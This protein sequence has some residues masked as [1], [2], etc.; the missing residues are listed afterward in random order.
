MARSSVVL[1]RSASV[2]LALVLLVLSPVDAQK[3]RT[4]GKKSGGDAEAKK[5]APALPLEGEADLRTFERTTDEVTWLSIDLSPDG[6]TLVLEVLGDL[7]VMPVAGGAATPLPGLEASMGFD[8]QPSISP[9][10]EWVAFV[11][12]RDGAE[13][14]WIAPLAGGEQGKPKQLTKDKKAAFLSPTWSADGDY[15]IVSRAALGFANFEL[16][17]FHVAGGAGVQLTQSNPGGALPRDRRLNAFGAVASPDQR[18]LYYSRRTGGFQYNASFP[19]WQIVRRDLVTGD[20]DVITSAPGSA[21]RPELSPD[22]RLLAYATRID[23]QTGIKVRE[24][25]TG[26]E[27]FVALPVVRDEQESRGTRDNFPGYSFTADGHALIA[28][29]DGKLFR[30]DVAGNTEPVA[31]PFEVTIKK[32]IGPRLHTEQRIEDGPVRARLAQ[33]AVLSPS[34]DHVAFSA[35]A[36]IYVAE[37]STVARGTEPAEAAPPVGLT[38]GD[39]EAY[40]PS[41]SPSG[42]T[43]AFVTWSREGGHIWTMPRTGGTPRRLTNTPAYYAQPT[44][45]PDGSKVVALRAARQARVEMPNEFGGSSLALDLVWVSASASDAPSNTHLIAPARGV[46]QPHFGPGQIEGEPERLYVHSPAGLVSMRLDGSDKRTHLQVKGPGFYSSEE[47]V[48]ANDLLIS[49]DGRWVLA[50]VSNRLFLIALPRVGGEAPTLDISAPSLPAKRISRLGADSFGFARAGSSIHWTVG[51][52]LFELELDAVQFEP[53]SAETRS[54]N[55]SAD[56][57]TKDQESKGPDAPHYPEARSQELVVEVE[58]SIPQGTLVLTG[59]RVITMTGDD[60]GVIEN[61]VVVIENNRIAAVGPAG[62]IDPPE[63][64]TVLDLS[65]KTVVPG[66]IDTHAHW[67]EI[68]RGVLDTDAWTFHAN[69]AYGVTTGLDVQTMTND[70]FAY[71]DMIDAG[72]MIGPRAF[73]TGPGIFSDNNFASKDDALALLER[74]RDHY[75]TR[76]LKAYISGNRQQRQ[77]IVQAASELGMMPTTE[78]AL[79]MKLDLTHAIDGFSGNEHSLPVVPIYKDVAELYAASGTGYTPTLLVSYGGPWAENWFYTRETVHDNKKLRRFVPHDV[80]DGVTRKRTWFRE[81]EHIFQALAESA[82][83]IVRAGGRVGVGA[84]GQ[85]QG[86]GYH[87]ELWALGSGMTELEALRAA[88]LHGAEIIGLEQEIGSIEPG[89]LADLV[90]LDANPLEDIRNSNTVFRVIKNGEVFEGETL[91]Q[92]WPVKRKLPAPWW[93]GR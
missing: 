79:D 15:V 21:M 72:R 11:S 51:S 61:G 36:R 31:I 60:G 76:N 49:P 32:K 85:L 74:Y 50:S 63:G 45:S 70:M 6:E 29:R 26:D 40:Q 81:G 64:T 68:R 19:L 54:E 18:F 48:P 88:T 87:W 1:V 66:F 62:T 77:W 10:G 57:D 59:A 9:N 25:E 83:K 38:R 69:L 47:P 90:V 91:H 53:P 14:V 55:E 73:S 84:H 13:N 17:M 80:I 44:F 92:L 16:F 24:L 86:L 22:G 89:K 56:Q 37:V 8:T 2:L 78:G 23:N 33:G 71:Q 41:W 42:E 3:K 75:R 5:E 28:S 27:R 82:A 12:D 67:T 4:R 30:F 34:G 43:L 93:E 58:R 7:Y 35:L 65:G 39:L 20:E 46:G 52:T